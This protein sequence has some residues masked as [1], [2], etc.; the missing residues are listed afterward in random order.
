VL[1]VCGGVGAQASSVPMPAQ[2]AANPTL[3]SQAEVSTRPS[4]PPG[5]C[6]TETDIRNIHTRLSARVI[7]PSNRAALYTELAKAERCP[8]IGRRYTYEDWKRLEG[9][10]RGDD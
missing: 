7:A 1:L 9:V 6:P 10:L 5:S 8:V 4:L 3:L 2:S